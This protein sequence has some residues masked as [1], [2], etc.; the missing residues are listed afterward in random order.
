MSNAT[1]PH[2]GGS[3]RAAGSAPTRP[4]IRMRILSWILPATMLLSSVTPAALQAQVRSDPSA[5]P[6]QGAPE[7]DPRESGPG[8]EPD[9]W[10]EF[11]IVGGLLGG[12]TGALI[13][14]LSGDDSPD[15]FS[16]DR[17]EKIA[18]MGVVGAAAGAVLGVAAARWGG[19]RGPRPAGGATLF[20]RPLTDVDGG[21]LR[22]GA[23]VP[24]GGR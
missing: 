8:S 7:R 22:L 14:H 5:E 10:V 9:R 17:G 18:V 16:L 13:G 21:G 12:A 4:V 24:V 3:C 11:M 6:A 2:L 15:L 23:S 20:V 1:D 19:V